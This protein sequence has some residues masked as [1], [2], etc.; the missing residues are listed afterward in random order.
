METKNVERNSGEKKKK[1]VKL[2]Q[3]LHYVI[4]LNRWNSFFWYFKSLS[5]ALQDL[6]EKLPKYNYYILAYVVAVT[7]GNDHNK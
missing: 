2:L 7:A 5:K 3:V 6:D 4:F 1:Q